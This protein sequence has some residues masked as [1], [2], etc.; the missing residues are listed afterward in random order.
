MGHQPGFD[1]L[2]EADAARTSRSSI[3]HRSYLFSLFEGD[4]CPLK[5][6]STH[7]VALMDAHGIMNHNMAIP[8]LR[9]TVT[10]VFRVVRY[11]FI[12]S[13]RPR[14]ETKCGSRHTSYDGETPS[15]FF[16]VHE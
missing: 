13:N 1:S 15:P 12:C 5:P 6:S 11:S 10:T 14:I 9:D 8:S 3:F 16:E 7:P 2:A 4:E